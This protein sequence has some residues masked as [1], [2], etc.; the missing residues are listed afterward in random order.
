MSTIFQ[1]NRQ[2]CHT[3]RE[4][5]PETGVRIEPP[6]PE[7]GAREHRE[8]GGAAKEIGLQRA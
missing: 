7:T 1:K 6:A 8:H 2:K 5:A 4:I 3:E